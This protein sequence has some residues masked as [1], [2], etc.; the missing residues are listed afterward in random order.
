MI[1]KP[2]P[3]TP[4]SV[5]T[6]AYLAAQAGFP[7]GVFNVLTTSLENTP[8]LSQRLCQHPEIKKVTFTGSVSTSLLYFMNFSSTIEANKTEIQTRIGKIVAQMCSGTLKKLT[9]ELGGNCPFIV[10]DD[11]DLEKALEGELQ[12]YQPQFALILIV[13]A[14][15]GL[16]WRHAGQACITANRVY[17]QAGIYE[18]F[19]TALV[20]RTSKLKIGHG[21]NDDTTI[22][23]VTTARSLERAKAQVDNAREKGAK[24]ALGGSVV[25]SAGFFFEPTIILDATPEMLITRE[26][27][28]AP[29]L[30]VYKFETE[31]EAVSAA[32]N[33][34]VRTLL[35]SII[36]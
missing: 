16:K 36:S 30:A 12:Q 28:F 11:A 15:M 8:P 29:V 24:I 20:E 19:T 33:T 4:L 27:T 9:L 22:G 21:A 17:V 6:L 7:K 14:L 1:V 3:E 13:S 18:R 5:L 31:D 25:G 32:N 35:N 23:P 34:S 26:E 2:S 10:F